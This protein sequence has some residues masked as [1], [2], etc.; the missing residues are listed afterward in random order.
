MTDVKR[1]VLRWHGGK[2]RLAPWVIR[3][4]PPHRI[5][6]EPF[7]GAGSVL[8]RKPRAYAEV[9]NDLDGD[10][11]TLFR[12]LRDEAQAA[13]LIELLKLTPFSRDEFLAAYEPTEDPV[14]RARR[15]VARCFMAHGTTARRVNQTGFRAKAYR[16]N[17]TGAQDFSTHPDTLEAVVFL[18]NAFDEKQRKLKEMM[19]H[20]GMSSGPLTDKELAFKLKVFD[21]DETLINFGGN[22]RLMREMLQSTTQIF[23]GRLM[24]E[25]NA[26][27]SSGHV[28]KLEQVLGVVRHLC[29][30]VM[31]DHLLEKAAKLQSTLNKIKRDGGTDFFIPE[32]FRRGFRVH[33]DAFEGAMQDFVRAKTWRRREQQQL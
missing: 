32:D 3:H 2:W 29:K 1:P 21:R 23:E 26:A 5:Y 13:R 24:P 28:S 30:V 10:V 4:F 18:N 12:V 33:C 14:E 11:V 6:V 9:Y 20:V 17:Q 8:L 7:G 27:S 25:I 15:L 31:S 22:D 16:Q 19:A